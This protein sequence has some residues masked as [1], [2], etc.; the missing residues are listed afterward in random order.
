MIYE[1]NEISEQ[2]G[3]FAIMRDEVQKHEVRNVASWLMRN[4]S[5]AIFLL[6]VPARDIESIEAR[7]LAC[8]GHAHAYG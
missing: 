4:V 1:D 5:K 3:T 8:S 2:K 7:C 6:N